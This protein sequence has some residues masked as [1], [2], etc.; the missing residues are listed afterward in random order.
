MVNEAGVSKQ[1]VLERS[2]GMILVGNY[3]KQNCKTWHHDN[4]NNGAHEQTFTARCDR[5]TYVVGH[6]V[7]LL[8]AIL[9]RAWK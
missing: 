8:Q 7:L 6:D 4:G 1:C 3:L 2:C 5:S 9:D